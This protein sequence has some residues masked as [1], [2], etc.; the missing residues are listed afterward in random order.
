MDLLA[1]NSYRETHRCS[2]GGRWEK[3]GGL[4]E[5]LAATGMAVQSIAVVLLD[6]ERGR[7]SQDATGKRA[8]THQSESWRRNV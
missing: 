1:V 7:A 3:R 8:G 2:I 5:P 6:D 4:I